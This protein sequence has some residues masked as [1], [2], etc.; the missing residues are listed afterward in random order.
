MSIITS[1]SFFLTEHAQVHKRETRHL[2]INY[3]ISLPIRVQI[4]KTRVPELHLL[5]QRY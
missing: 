3:N 5:S 2:F 1:A 4:V